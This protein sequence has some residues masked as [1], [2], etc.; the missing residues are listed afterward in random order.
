MEILTCLLFVMYL[1]L[2]EMYLPW[3]KQ[4]E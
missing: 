1:V 3:A 4:E 2:P